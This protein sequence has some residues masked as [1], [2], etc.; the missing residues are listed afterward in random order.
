MRLAE[1][2]SGILNFSELQRDAEIAQI[3]ENSAKCKENSL[4]VCIKGA[5]ADGHNYAA[6][7]YRRGCRCFVA[8]RPFDLPNDAIVLL[9]PN[10]ELTLAQLS[11]RFYG[12]PSH[13]MTLIGITGTKGKTTVACMLADLLIRSGIPCG[14]IGSNGISYGNTHLPT[15]NTTP[16]AVTLQRSLRDM[17]QA[18]VYTAVLEVSSQ[19]LLRHRADGIRFKACVFTNL[20]PDHIGEGEHTDYEDYRRCKQRLFYEFGADTLFVNRDDPATSFMLLNRAKEKICSFGSSS[21][22]DYRVEDICPYLEAARL[23]N[24]FTVV[25]KGEGLPFD[26][27]LIGLGN[28]MNALTVASVAK[29]LFGISLQNAAFLLR[30]ARIAGRCETLELPNGAMAVIDYAHNGTALRQLLG[31][32]REVKENRLIC[33][34]GSV[35]ERTALRRVELGYVAAELSDL[36]VLTSDNPGTEDPEKIILEMAQG[37]QNSPTPYLSIPDRAEAIREAARRSQRGDIL[38]LAGKGHE[39]Y[40]LIGKQ[41]LPFS[42]REILLSSFAVL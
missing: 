34:V 32:L 36:C 20:S 35:G 33:L 37:F 14:Y 38:V 11:C 29:E 5:K 31:T 26:I 7:A 19:A 4:F 30:D 15:A 8:E 1:L 28:V 17:R 21:A 3:T 13:E 10:S 18:G 24:R 27:P 2:I 42:E 39:S 22:A 25:H 6:D 23:G 12:D 41:K 16:D 9:S 40:Q